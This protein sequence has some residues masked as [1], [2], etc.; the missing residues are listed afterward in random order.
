[1]TRTLPPILCALVT[2]L[3]ANGIHAA[4]LVSRYQFENNLNDT[5]GYV[6]TG[7]PFNATSAT[8]VDLTPVAYSTSI[9]KTGTASGA[10]AGNSYAKVADNATQSFTTSF[11]MSSWVYFTADSGTASNEVIASKWGNSSN[12]SYQLYRN[13]SSDKL[14][15]AISTDGQSGTGHVSTLVSSTTLSLNTWYYVAGVYDNSEV[16]T[17]GAAKMTIYLYSSAGSL[18]ESTSL[19]SGVVASVFDSNALFTIGSAYDNLATQRL[20]GYLDDLRLYNGAL[21]QAE[22]GAL[23]AIPEPGTAGLA[24]AAGLACIVMTLRKRT[25]R[26]T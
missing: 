13:N 14:T 7:S 9:V 18:L 8:G 23:A 16:S 2:L 15:F 1:M 25:R 4:T 17:G 3:A 12:R 20:D 19:T 10:F 6:A 21:T 24:L 26:R 11:S 5:S 22:V